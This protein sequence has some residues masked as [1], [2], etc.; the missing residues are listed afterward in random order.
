MPIFNFLLPRHRRYA[1]LADAF[2]DGELGGGDLSRFEAHLPTCAN[3]QAAVAEARLLKTSVASLPELTAPRSF[4]LTPEMVAAPATAPRPAGTPL[5][6]GLVRAGAALSVAAFATVIAVSAFDSEGQQSAD[7]DRGGTN[8]IMLTGAA[9]DST[10][11]YNSGEDSKSVPESAAA[12]TIATP[13]PQL[14]P[15]TQG[16][17][18]GAGAGTPA[19]DPP[20]PRVPAT[21]IDP[22]AT[23]VQT[24]TAQRNTTND[25]FAATPA[26]GGLTIDP[27]PDSV[28]SSAPLAAS[29]KDDDGLAPW[30]VALGVLA[31]VS[32]GALAL[33]ELSRR[34]RTS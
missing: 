29:A 31:A 30:T 13:S 15:A 18:S 8:E 26:P 22:N 2:V 10:N 12:T 33:L 1:R 19:A 34:R 14:A 17:A 23:P 6:L 27:V 9:A 11:Q 7:R 16:G 21:G 4:R 24:E 20:T 32:L 3:C 28:A 25:S 5:Y